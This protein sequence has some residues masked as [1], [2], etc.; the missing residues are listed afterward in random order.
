M[1]IDKDAATAK[2]WLHDATVARSIGFL[3]NTSG[4]SLNG[5]TFTNLGFKFT[6]ANETISAS[7][8]NLVAGANDT[9]IDGSTA[10]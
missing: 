8:G 3:L 5:G 10:N 1:H 4:F 9:L 7:N 6:S 2:V